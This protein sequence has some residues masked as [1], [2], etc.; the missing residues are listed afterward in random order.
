LKNIAK[1]CDISSVSVFNRIK[2]LKDLGVIIGAT[3]FPR[4]DEIG[5]HI[6]ATIGMETDQSAEEITEFFE[7]HTT[8]IE[9]STMIG[10]YDFCALVYAEDITSLNQKI[11]AV[12]K[13]FGIEKI[14]VNIWSGIPHICFENIDLNPTKR[15]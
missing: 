3:V 14:V 2:R 15:Q 12:R 1:T 6:V 7:E 8:L 13:R 5:F 11:N 10:E 4:L 9:P